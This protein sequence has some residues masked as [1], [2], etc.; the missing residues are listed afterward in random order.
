M[1]C[2]TAPVSVDA[3]ISESSAV[4]GGNAYPRRV[5]SMGT[6]GCS[7]VERVRTPLGTDGT[8]HDEHVLACSNR[9]WAV[10]FPLGTTAGCSCN[11]AGT[12][13][14]HHPLVCCRG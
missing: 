14:D 11:T 4:V 7:V 1:L 5:N 8:V 2:E 12:S 3:G 9:R 6:A 13:P 10:H